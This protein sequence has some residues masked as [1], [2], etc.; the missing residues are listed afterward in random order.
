MQPTHVSQ[1]VN[2]KVSNFIYDFKGETTHWWKELIL[3][4]INHYLCNTVPPIC[5]CMGLYQ[6][7]CL[8]MQPHETYSE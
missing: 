4:I 3:C 1:Q 5:K 2:W 8:N 6:P 7:M